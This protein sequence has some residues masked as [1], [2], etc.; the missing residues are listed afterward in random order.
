MG[1]GVSPWPVLGVS[2]EGCGPHPDLCWGCRERAVNGG[3][4]TLACAGGVG[5]GLWA[6]PW[7][8]LGVSGE[9]CERWESHPGLCWGCRERAVGLTLACAGGVGRGL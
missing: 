9:G 3:S 7:P 6:S 4:L 5:R 8:V 1:G 2:G